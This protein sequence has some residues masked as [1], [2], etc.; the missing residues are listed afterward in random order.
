VSWKIGTGTLK[1]KEQEEKEKKQRGEE[2]EK[3]G[4]PEAHKGKMRKT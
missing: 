3:I 4:G 2:R 1:C